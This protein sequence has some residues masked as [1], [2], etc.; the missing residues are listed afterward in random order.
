MT[1]IS[2]SKSVEEVNGG[3]SRRRVAKVDAIGL[4]EDAAGFVRVAGLKLDLC[5]ISNRGN[6]LWS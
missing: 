2:S 1:P 4:H 6:A 5:E 3:G